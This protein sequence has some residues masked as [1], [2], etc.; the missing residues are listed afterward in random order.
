MDRWPL[1]DMHVHATRYR[2]DGARPEMTVAGIARR[3]DELGCAYAG[4]VEHLDTAPKHP[5]SCLQA[6]VGEFRAVRSI[7]TLYVGAELDYQN[8]AISVPAAPGIKDRLGLDFCLAAAH[9]VGDNVTTA[10]AYVQDQHRR[11][12]GIIEGCPYVDVIAHPWVEGRGHAASG[13]IER[14]D[15]SLIPERYLR[16]FAEAAA[17]VGKAVEISRKVLPDVD[18][19][20]LREYLVTLRQ[21]NVRVTVA[22]DAHSMDGVGDVTPLFGL[23]QNAGFVSTALWRPGAS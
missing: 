21:A 22:S 9:G 11:L 20:A 2:L 8:G 12:M 13:R 1:V 18:D 15:W 16:E 23:L 6:L 19:P 14:W 17:S 5:V 4:V 10:A 7:C 3:L